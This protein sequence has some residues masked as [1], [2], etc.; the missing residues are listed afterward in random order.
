MNR[1]RLCLK[2]P[3]GWPAFT[4]LEVILALALSV[5]LIAAV[6]TA[7]HVHLRLLNSG[8]TRVEEAQLARALLG[9]IANDL[10]GAV[11]YNPMAAEE[12]VPELPDE[13]DLLQQAADAGYDIGSVAADQIADVADQA[14]DLADS[15]VPPSIPGLYGNSTE[16]LVDTSRLPRLDQYDAEWADRL[17]DVKTVAYYI[18]D[19]LMRRELDRATTAWAAE[20][21]QLG[22]LELAS[23]PI[24]P[25][26]VAIEFRYYDGAEWVDVWDTAE[27]A[28]LPMAVEIAIAIR[29]SGRAADNGSAGASLAQLA[30]ENDLLIYRLIVHLPAAW[31][32]TDGEEVAE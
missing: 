21:G 9:Q 5:L 16:L 22:D 27:R 17:S 10:R 14:E 24:A 23:Q 15:A 12:M 18:D 19:G 7:I 30:A 13:E 1:T 4:L 28:G 26:V 11:P 32:T 20:Q 8:R 25:E 29:S 3:S 2:S 31:P 6:G